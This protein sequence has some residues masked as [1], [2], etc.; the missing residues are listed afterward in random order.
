M[1]KV[2]LLIGVSEYAEPDLKPL[3]N[4]AKD[5]EAIARVLR[6]EEI[7]GFDSDQ[8]IVL[9]NPSQSVAQD[10]IHQLFAQRQKDDLLLFYFS[11]HGVRDERGSLY[12][13]MPETRKENGRLVKHTAIAAQF[14]HDEMG[15][16]RSDHQV[17]I[18][19]CCFSGAIAQGMSAKDDGS[20][21]LDQQLGGK[22]RAILTSSNSIEYSFAPD[23]LPLSV[24]THHLVEGLEKGAADLDGDGQ[25]AADEL[26]QYVFDQVKRAAPAMTPQFFPVRDGYR[27][28]LARSPQDD[29]RVKYRRKVQEYVKSGNYRLEGDRFSVAA[30]RYLD[31]FYK[32]LKLTQD[33]VQEVEAEVLEPIREY[34]QKLHEYADAVQETVEDEG[35]PFSEATSKVLRDFQV[36]FG[37]RDEDVEGV[38]QSVTMEKWVNDD[39]IADFSD[40]IV[41]LEQPEPDLEDDLS[42]EQGIDYTRLRDLLKSQNWEIANLETFRVVMTALGRTFKPITD[43]DLIE[44]EEMLNF[45]CKDLK[46][47]DDLWVRHSQGRFGFRVQ[48]QIY[49][50]CGGQ[51]D[52]K[53]PSQDIWR[54]FGE[55][56]GWRSEKKWVRYNNLIT[57]PSI[58]YRQGTFPYFQQ[59]T[60]IQPGFFNK[61]GTANP[62]AFAM[63]GDDDDNLDYYD[64]KL[65]FW[66]LDWRVWVALF[67]HK[68]L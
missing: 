11:G 5:G 18:F 27:I 46:T 53:E 35:F 26:H 51:L 54:K 44:R 1:K 50:E 8:V 58:F 31:R 49:V 10:A 20:I 9:V 61:D 13:A 30:R 22:G 25:I 6:R 28:F 43:K 23:D 45:P 65:G 32:T 59:A 52:G 2:A 24:Y 60:S 37:L 42:S 16:S 67:S 64:Y 12:L 34:Q 38:E 19:D 68:V 40:E 47:I 57:N 41:S 39:S 48:K 56:V 21:A 17:L 36:L 15:D 4:A 14:L 66:C 3:P 29:P 62:F 63:S 33:A 55:R 7:G